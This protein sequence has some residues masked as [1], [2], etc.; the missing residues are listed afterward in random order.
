[1]IKIQ[2]D[3]VKKVTSRPHRTVRHI[4]DKERGEYKTPQCS[5]GAEYEIVQFSN[6]EDDKKDTITVANINGNATLVGIDSVNLH[7]NEPSLF[8]TF[9]PGDIVE[10]RVVPKDTP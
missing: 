3:S 6:I 7:I 5:I 9:K 1:M 4:W 10:L 2:V 8:G